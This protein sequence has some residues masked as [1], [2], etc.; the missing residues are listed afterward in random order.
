M[1]TI[2]VNGTDMHYTERGDGPTVVALHAATVS[3]KQL[4]W[5]SSAVVHEGFNVV[6]PDL[7]GHGETPNPAPDMHLP[8]LVEDILEFIYL[9]G[10]TPVHA[11]GYSLGGAVA[12]YAAQQR[13][14]VF[15]SLVL[16]GTNYRA[17]SEQ[18]LRQIIGPPEARE[19]MVQEVF[20]TETG[21]IVGWEKPLDAFRTIVAPTLIITGDRDEFNDPQDNLDLYKKLP[22]AELLV[23]PRTDHLGLVR[24][25]MV[26]RAVGDFYGHVPR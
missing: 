8:R 12:L 22:N 17:P 18:R 20:D 19:G 1:P 10:R 13:P 16:L 25:P 15:R 26:F 7:R 2:R 4:G 3:S 14:D 11:L 23:V 24:H 9:L 6:T 21:C 5:L